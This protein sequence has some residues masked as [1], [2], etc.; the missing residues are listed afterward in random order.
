LEKKGHRRATRRE[1]ENGDE[2]HS[3]GNST[4]ALPSDLLFS[5][6][7]STAKTHH[8]TQEADLQ[9]QAAS[10]PSNLCD[11]EKNK[12]FEE[13]EALGTKYRKKRWEH[14]SIIYLGILLQGKNNRRHATSMVSKIQ[15]KG[16]TQNPCACIRS[17]ERSTFKKEDPPPSHV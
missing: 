3:T 8:H 1:R 12:V 14:P 10:L 5:S 13:Q 4:C 16:I 9:P 11:T 6:F 17:K 15:P 2:F 7:P